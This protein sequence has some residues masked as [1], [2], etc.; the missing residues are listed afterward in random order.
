MYFVPIIIKFQKDL[1]HDGK[2]IARDLPFVWSFS[3]FFFLFSAVER[4]EFLLY[5]KLHVLL[6]LL[7]LKTSARKMRV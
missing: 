1:K 3:L 2:Q 5:N 7:I 6:Y 4:N